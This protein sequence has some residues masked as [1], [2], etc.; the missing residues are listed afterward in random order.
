MI[1]PSWSIQDY[2]LLLDGLTRLERPVRPLE[3]FATGARCIWLRH[4]VELDLG[5]AV[6]LARV[7]LLAGIGSSF[8]LCPESPAV[9]RHGPDDVRRAALEILR[10]GHFVSLHLVVSPGLDDIEERA[11]RYSEVLGLRSTAVAEAL[12]FHAPGVDAKVLAALPGGA[13]VYGSMAAGTCAY[14]SDSTGRWRWGHPGEISVHDQRAM[15]VLTHP[16]WWSKGQRRRELR[17]DEEVRVF[18]P[19]HADYRRKEGES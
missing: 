10:M 2:R 9:A 15:Q 8:F 4:D 14:F 18:L 12:T 7:E 11:F 5:A 13:A 3:D 17:Y 19:Q 16:F 1:F 6:R